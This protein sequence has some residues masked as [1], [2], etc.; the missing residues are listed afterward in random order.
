MMIDDTELRDIFK[1]SSEERLQALDQ[2]LLHL[3]KHPDDRDTIE[4]LMREAHS[5]KGDGNMLGVTDLGQ[6]AHQI[7][8]VLGAIA[9]AEQPLSADLF[10]R[11]A[12][13][14]AALRAIAHEAVTGEPSGVQVA[15]AIA[16]LTGAEPTSAPVLPQ[17]HGLD[18]DGAIF[19]GDAIFDDAIFD[20]AI[21]E[22]LAPATSAVL[23]P[24]PPAP[25]VTDRS[26]RYIA[27]DELRD[28]FK[29]TSTEH[30]QALDDGLLHLEKHPDNG[31][32]IEALMRVAHTLKGDSNMLGVG[33]LGKLAHHIEHILGA[34]SR[35]EV[36]VD[37]DLS[38]RLGHGLNAMKQLAHEATTGELTGVNVF[39]V[40]AEL[41]GAATARKPDNSPAAPAEIQN[42]KF[43]VTSPP[44]PSSPPPSPAPSPSPSPP[45]TPHPSPPTPATALTANYRIETIRVPTTALDALMTHSG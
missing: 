41:M 18:I 3:E 30:L 29:T 37:S 10:D 11:L 20:G 39:Y 32:V 24:P 40:L 35:G 23:A 33:E 25:T 43:K 28:I 22:P 16:Q 2:G 26:D 38:D 45:L 12:Q 27:D 17:D 7:E 42:S 8:H 5:L 31:T 34:V 1:I 6:V 15:A 9:R 13:G 14:V 4:A 21:L 44:S 36:P 19:T